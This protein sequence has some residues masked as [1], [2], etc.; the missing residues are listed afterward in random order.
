MSM[1]PERLGLWQVVAIG[2]GG[3]VGGGIFAV[4]GLAV[5]RRRRSADRFEL[6]PPR[7]PELEPWR[8]HRVSRPCLRRRSAERRTERAALAELC[9]H[10]LAVCS[11]VWQLLLFARAGGPARLGCTHGALVRHCRAHRTQHLER[12]PRWSASP[13]DERDCTEVIGLRIGTTPASS[14]AVTTSNS[15]TPTSVPKSRSVTFH[16]SCWTLEPFG[17]HRGEFDSLQ[18]PSRVS[19]THTTR[20]CPTTA[21][22]HALLNSDH[23]SRASQR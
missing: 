6:R 14:G 17:A 11:G 1:S 19:C 8:H 20:T 22:R 15:S 2:V 23:R 7:R 13:M 3:M 16:R 5:G 12:R 21:L 10:A 4:L 18:R 9:D